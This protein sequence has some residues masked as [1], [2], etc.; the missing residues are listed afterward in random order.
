ML[1][2]LTIREGEDLFFKSRN[3]HLEHS[4]STGP[5][6]PESEILA[7][8]DERTLVLPKPLAPDVCLDG[9]WQSSSR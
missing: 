5:T 8:V 2:S 9:V 1:T 4:T 3:T 6:A 7:T